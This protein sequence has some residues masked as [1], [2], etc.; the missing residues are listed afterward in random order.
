VFDGSHSGT[1]MEPGFGTG[2][3]VADIVQRSSNSSIRSR[4]RNRSR[5]RLRT[6]RSAAFRT[7]GNRMANPLLRSHVVGS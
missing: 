4:T 5:V 2:T 6:H 1:G 3:V 7:E